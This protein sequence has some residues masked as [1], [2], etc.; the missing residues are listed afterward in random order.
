[1]IL[2]F[3][4]LGYPFEVRKQSLYTVGS[5]HSWPALV[6]TLTW[7]IDVLEYDEE[8][9]ART[10]ADCFDADRT[11]KI[12]FDYLSKAYQRFLDGD[13]DSPELD[14]ELT[15]IFESRN[16]QV[17]AE[18]AKL[19]DANAELRAQLHALRGAPSP[20]E[21]ATK[22]SDDLQSDLG[23]FKKLVA[24]M[25]AHE[26][27]LTSK[28]GERAKD[29]HATH[30]ELAAVNG[31]IEQLRAQL[32]V[33]EL[34]PA[35]VLRM[36]GERARLE[37]EL[38]TLIGAK[39]DKESEVLK[40]EVELSRQA[41]AVGAA[42]TEYTNRATRLQLVPASAANARGRDFA[43][44]LVGAPAAGA[45]GGA[46]KGLSI[47]LLEAIKP[48]LAELKGAFT[49][50]L[51]TAQEDL[52]KLQDHVDRSEQSKQDKVDELA[53]LERKAAKL[54]AVFTSEKEVMYGDVDELTR[55]AEAV[56]SDALATRHTLATQRSAAQQA[57]AAL[58]AEAEASRRGWTR[59]R[60]DMN[61]ALI[62][63]LDRLMNHK[64]TIRDRLQSVLTAGQAAQQLVGS[65]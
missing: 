57:L 30:A 20:L 56:L 32:A 44:E 31:E 48:A 34:S 58:G 59:E 41:D 6:A 62:R 51:R 46:A 16:G 26:T 28:V 36:N 10:E 47:E 3:K 64:E 4:A 14:D 40:T 65:T 17:K 63:T 42:L 15:M 29:L 1:V 37:A 33:Q 53:G 5:Q 12:F 25:G 35:D 61:A 22:Q 18:I 49:A 39:D 7:L 52:L 21:A 11:F 2:I 43:C 38:K 23:K 19:S 27:Q 45:P 54:E 8:V 13:D 9:T 50:A 55:R 60:D 24:Q